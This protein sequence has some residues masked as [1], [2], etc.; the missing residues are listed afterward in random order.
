MEI[1]NYDDEPIIQNSETIKELTIGGIKFRP[2]KIMKTK[3]D[4]DLNTHIDFMMKFVSA[5]ALSLLFSILL[6]AL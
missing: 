5:L 3:W 2:G 4:V 6:M 1:K